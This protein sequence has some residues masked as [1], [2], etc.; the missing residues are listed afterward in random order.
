MRVRISGR[1]RTELLD[2][3]AFLAKRNFA[4]AERLLQEINL[5]LRQLSHFPFMGRERPEFARNLRSTLVQTYLIFYT[6]ADEQVVIMRIVD[7]RMDVEK[8]FQQ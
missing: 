1:A 4:A 7:G 6:V 3:Y 5:K 2:I 8:E